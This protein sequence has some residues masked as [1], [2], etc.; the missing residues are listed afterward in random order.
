MSATS[1]T[2]EFRALVADDDKIVC[3][4]VSYALTQEGFICNTATD[5]VHALALLNQKPYD[6]VMTDLHMPN[7]NG[8]SL[9]VEL[10]E[11][12]FRPVVMVHTA[13]KD[14]NL[15]RDMTLRG[16]DDIS[17]KPTDYELLASKA[18][19]LAERRREKREGE[20]ISPN[21]ANLEN[22]KNTN[23][24]LPVKSNLTNGIRISPTKVYQHMSQLDTFFPLSH[25]P[26]DVYS[27]ASRENVSVEELAQLI[28]Q[29]EALTTEILNLANSDDSISE[30]NETVDLEKAILLLGC[31]RIGELAIMS[32]AKLALTSCSAPWINCDLLWKRSLAA[33]KTVR[34]I[35]KTQFTN[36]DG[37]A[38][39]CALLHPIGR[40]ILATLFPEEHRELTEHC[41]ATGESLD[42]AE[43][44]AF[45][46]SYGQ[47]AARFCSTWR[48]PATSRLPLEHLTRTFDEMIS[49]P[50]PARQNIEIVKLSLLLSRIAM[51]LWEPCDIIDIP[52]RA[53]LNKLN[54]PSVQRTLGLIQ[55]AC[56]FES[57]PQPLQPDLESDQ[58]LPKIATLIEYISTAAT[59]SDLLF[60]LLNSLGLNIHDQQLELAHLNLIDG[61]SLGNKHLREFIESQ[62]LPDSVG[63]VR[64]YKD[65]SLFKPGAAIC[66]PTTVQKLFTFFTS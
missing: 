3:R 30:S 5:G 50:D 39:L 48:I 64:H 10:L 49:L 2:M 63:I 17:F 36:S 12:E 1:Q 14:P 41:Q 62:N 4:M 25:V 59:T 65:A 47:I 11:Q 42:L 52:R 66:L 44:A 56:I 23:E 37:S 51:S 29:D 16:V 24:M 27:L 61:V 28:E 22:K 31:Q 19:G 20:D 33:S 53:V 15:T 21:K 60:P 34:I 45:G 13:I 40:I 38:F 54:M 26:F 8:H 57:L 43:E 35:E 7:K 46:L 18:R 9:A 32:G 58:I 6:L 55:E